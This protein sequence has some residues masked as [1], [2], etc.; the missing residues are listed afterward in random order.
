MQPTFY[1]E[2]AKRHSFVPALEPFLWNKHSKHSDSPVTD[3][4]PTMQAHKL[5]LCGGLTVIWLFVVLSKQNWNSSPLFLHCSVKMFLLGPAA[6]HSVKAQ[7]SVKHLFWSVTGSWILWERGI[8][9]SEER[10]I[11]GQD[12]PLIYQAIFNKTPFYTGTS[13]LYQRAFSILE[14]LVLEEM[15]NYLINNFRPSQDKG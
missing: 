13:S 5:C 1:T 15:Y 6:H 8:W 7:G 9:Y 2:W 12:L 14:N 3:R 11:C 10:C 4:K